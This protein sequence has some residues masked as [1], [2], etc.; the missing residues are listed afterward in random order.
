MANPKSTINNRRHGM[1][2]T[3]EYY[4]WR[5]M[6]HRC[7]AEQSPDY[8]Y[9]GARGIR[10]CDRWLKF[11]NFY[12]D[13]GKRPSSEHSLERIDNNGNYEPTNCKWATRREQT[14][15]RRRNRFLTFQGRTLTIA[16]WARETGLSHDCIWRRI[17]NDWSVEK[18]L[19]TPVIPCH[20]RHLKQSRF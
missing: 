9:Y 19:T 15:N 11:Q 1:S 14:V 20:L 4:A 18:A 6:K 8:K 5:A 13:M 12:A 16:D 10:V 2:Q 17:D 3:P 7:S